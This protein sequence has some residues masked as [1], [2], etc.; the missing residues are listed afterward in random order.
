MIEEIAIATGLDPLDVRARNV[1]GT[2]TRNITPYHMTVE[3][4]IAADMMTQLAERCDYRERR[5]ACGRP[6]RAAPLSNA[7]SR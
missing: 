7:V 5:Q 4:S 2:G 6:I 1:Y 3:D